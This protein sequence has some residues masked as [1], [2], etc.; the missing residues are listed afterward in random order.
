[1]IDLAALAALFY[2]TSKE[3]REP[4]V[5]RIAPLAAAE[6]EPIVQAIKAQGHQLRWI[7]E[8]G[9]RQMARDGWKPVTE[10]DKIGRPSIFMDKASE[11][12]LVHRPATAA[13]GPA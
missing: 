4:T 12:L 2:E 13:S 1:M 10:R 7:R 3:W 9:L 6:Q 5:I 8:E 11:L